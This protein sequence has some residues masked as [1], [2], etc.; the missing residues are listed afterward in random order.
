MSSVDRTGYITKK[1]KEYAQ[2]HPDYQ[3]IADLPLRLHTDMFTSLMVF[4]GD[5]PGFQHEGNFFNR[6]IEYFFHENNIGSRFIDYISDPA[7]D[8]AKELEEKFFGYLIEIWRFYATWIV[9]CDSVIDVLRKNLGITLSLRTGLTART[10]NS[11][12]VYGET[13]VCFR[14]NHSEFASIRFQG[15]HVVNDPSYHSRAG[16]DFGFYIS[17]DWSEAYPDN[18]DNIIVNVPNFSLAFFDVKLVD[19]FGAKLA[20]EEQTNIGTLSLSVKRFR[21]A[22]VKELEDYKRRN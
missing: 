17:D 21:D 10:V 9:V 5:S 12:T 2:Q 20:E 11:H 6:T 4:D 18:P 15:P 13:G 22:L 8:K 7:N 1:F 3:K 19:R 14:Y 16:Y